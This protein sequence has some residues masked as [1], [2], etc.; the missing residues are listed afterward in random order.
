MSLARAIESEWL[1]EL[2]PD[3]PRALRSRRDIRRL[4]LIMGHAGI[5]R[6][7]LL[8]HHPRPAT[9]VELGAGDGTFMLAL[10]RQTGHR[11]GQRHSR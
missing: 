11:P 1:D 10:A 2:P 6:R 5:L 7:Q 3:D 8:K 9:I 4:N